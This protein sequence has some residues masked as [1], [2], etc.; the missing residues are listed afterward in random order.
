MTIQEFNNKYKEY[1][2]LNHY[3]LDIHEEKVIEY[4]DKEF[5]KII[6]EHPTFVYYQIKLKWG[7]ARVYTNMSDLTDILE[8][9]INK[10]IKS[11]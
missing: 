10:I 7:E 5:K 9:G 3:G 8:D 2:A 4:L 11:L 6:T 1:L